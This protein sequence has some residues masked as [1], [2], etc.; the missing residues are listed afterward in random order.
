MPW[1]G[2][3]DSERSLELRDSFGSISSKSMNLNNLPP[4]D[5]RI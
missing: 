2:K 3:I 5:I 1:F 4:D